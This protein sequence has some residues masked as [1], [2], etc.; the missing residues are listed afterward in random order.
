MDTDTVRNKLA[1]LER[2]A[3]ILRQ[4]L[5]IMEGGGEPDLHP[6]GNGKRRPLRA[7]SRTSQPEGG[8]TVIGLA[9]AALGTLHSYVTPRQLAKFILEVNKVQVNQGTLGSILWRGAVDHK[10]FK[11]GRKK[12]TY[13][14]IAWDIEGKASASAPLQSVP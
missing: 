13:G 14:L 11:K 7:A 2:Q 1:A 10:T 8:Q 9:E 12:G 3:D 6:N 5:K 4:A